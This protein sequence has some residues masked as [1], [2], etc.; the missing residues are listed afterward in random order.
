MKWPFTAIAALI[1]AIL[2]DSA[3]ANCSG[4]QC[5]SVLV[6]RMYIVS[7]TT[8]IRTSG[9]EDL[10]DCDAGS[11]D[12]LAMRRSDVEYDDW[13]ALVLTAFVQ[14][15]PIN[16]QLEGGTGNCYVNYIYQDR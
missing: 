5:S 14:Q 9:N 15:A 13:Y 16:V 4:N 12:Y 7:G 6:T 8:R 2:P 1:L 10:L 3:S 11:G